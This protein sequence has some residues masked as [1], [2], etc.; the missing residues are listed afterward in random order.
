MK[1]N[2]IYYLIVLVLM[3]SCNTRQEQNN[4]KHNDVDSTLK[5]EK[6]SSTQNTQD[7]VVPDFTAND[8]DGIP[9]KLSN[10]YK[11]KKV[12]LIDFW[13]SWCGP[14]RMENPN[15]V[16]AYQKY[17]SKGFDIISVSLDK[18][19]E[20]WLAAIKEDKLNWTHV[21]ELKYWNS[22]IAKQY[23]VQSIPTNFLIDGNGKLI[24]AELRGLDLE[25]KLKEIL[26]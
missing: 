21:S 17:H 14:C 26:N 2:I 4:T 12:V 9:L 15:V 5:Q 24:A 8:I 1:K 3:F 16:A 13:A 11:G 19:K 20:A 7:I 22:E 10:F 18:T 6:T 25:I 23:G